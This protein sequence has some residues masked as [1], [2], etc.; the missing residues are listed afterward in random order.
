MAR[1][2]RERSTA[3]TT[4]L[5]L[6]PADPFEPIRWLAR[7]QSDPRKAVAELVQNSLDAGARDV[8]VRRQRVRG[9][10]CLLV[11]DDG[12]GVLPELA[13]EDALKYLATNVGHSRKMGLTPAERASGS[14]CPRRWTCRAM[15]P[16]A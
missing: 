6:K 11:R 10:M 3:T 9:A 12:E 13:R 16:C 2:R 7:S 15:R 5:Q 4:S 8:D 14:S 1:R